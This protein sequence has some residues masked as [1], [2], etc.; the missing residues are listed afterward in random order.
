MPTV[1]RS[2]GIIYRLGGRT[3]NNFTPKPKDLE[4]IAGLREPGLST[5]EHLKEGEAGFAIDLSRLAYPLR[6]FAD[7]PG[8]PGRPGHLAIAPV[9][10][11]GAVDVERLDEWIASREMNFNHP[12][13]QYL[14]DAVIPEKVKGPI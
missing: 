6:A 14:L 8:S 10:Q 9:D 7:D 11:S 3:Q 12:F 5:L 13:T 1:W 2:S 4:G